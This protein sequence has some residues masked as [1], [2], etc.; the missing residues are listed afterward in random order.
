[1]KK[2]IKRCK[3]CG[4]DLSQVKHDKRAAQCARCRNYK[5][6]YGIHGG[7]VD[8]MYESQNRCCY[9]CDT[10]LERYSNTKKNAVHLDHNHETGFIRKILCMKC[11]TMIGVIEGLGLN[12]DRV[13][14]Y[15]EIK[16]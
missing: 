5:H 6:R 7:E 14:N 2:T 9:L 15:L 12:L 13:K 8:K 10:P 1:M 16:Q 4:D 3:H 11:N